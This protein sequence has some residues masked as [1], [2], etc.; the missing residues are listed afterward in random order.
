[1]DL[2][3]AFITKKKMPRKYKKALSNSFLR[4]RLTDQ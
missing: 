3:R 2:N 1:M 4:A